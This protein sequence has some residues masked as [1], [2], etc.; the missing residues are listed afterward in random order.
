MK[1]LDESIGGLPK[2]PKDRPR[3]PFMSDIY[4]YLQN[5]YLIEYVIERYGIDGELA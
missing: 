2:I 3:R 1:S 4:I 5:R